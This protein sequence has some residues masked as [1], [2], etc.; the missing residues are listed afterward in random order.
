MKYEIY[1]TVFMYNIHQHVVVNWHLVKNLVNLKTLKLAYDILFL[2]FLTTF[3]THCIEIGQVCK[4]FGNGKSS[5]P[6]S[7]LQRKAFAVKEDINFKT[8][9]KYKKNSEPSNTAQ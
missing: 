3:V 2:V 9:F 8:Q 7:C 1:G 5:Y 4:I 6:M